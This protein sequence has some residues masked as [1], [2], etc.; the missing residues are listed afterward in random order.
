MPDPDIPIGCGTMLELHRED[1]LVGA[2]RCQLLGTRI[3]I[4]IAQ[5]GYKRHGHR[6]KGIDPESRV[7][8][9]DLGIQ[10]LLSMAAELFAELSARS[11][12]M[13]AELFAELADLP[14]LMLVYISV[15]M[16]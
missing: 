7:E 14:V 9:I 13:L 11:A 8:A 3:Q 4:C 12:M 10:D 5:C 6:E 15:V 16:P 2:L 1:I